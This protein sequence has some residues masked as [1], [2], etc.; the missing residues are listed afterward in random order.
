MNTNL[1]VLV[2][3][4]GCFRL[5]RFQTTSPLTTNAPTFD[6]LK[7]IYVRRSGYNWKPWRL[8]VGR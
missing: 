4:L 3:R 2:T 5:K 7:P 8:S 6:H 1:V